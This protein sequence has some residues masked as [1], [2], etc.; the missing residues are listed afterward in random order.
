MEGVEKSS[1]L[2]PHEVSSFKRGPRV[3]KIIEIA[4]RNVTQGPSLTARGNPKILAA[5]QFQWGCKSTSHLT[6]AL[7]RPTTA[8]KGKTPREQAEQVMALLVVRPLPCIYSTVEE[9]AKGNL[10]T[11]SMIQQ[12][13]EIKGEKEAIVCSDLLDHGTMEHDIP[14]MQG[15]LRYAFLPNEKVDTRGY[16]RFWHGSKL[17]TLWSVLYHGKLKASNDVRRGEAYLEG[18]PGVYAHDDAGLPSCWNYVV[19][20][21]LGM[22]GVLHAII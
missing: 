15:C 20:Q 2:E 16:K 18:K 5:H 1:E 14:G 17:Q 19:H 21:E 6:K 12:A 10:V 11:W 22:S 3:S 4:Q 7:D 9:L 13:A 8:V